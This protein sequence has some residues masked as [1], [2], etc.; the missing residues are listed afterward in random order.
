MGGR[1]VV[2]QRTNMH[3][4]ITP[5]HIGWWSPGVGGGGGLEV[6]NGR[7]RGAYVILATIKMKKEDLS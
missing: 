2:N 5:G 6:V 7:K 3:L 4:C 1:E